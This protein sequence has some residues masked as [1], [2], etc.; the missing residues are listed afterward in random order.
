[1]RV[2]TD[3][4]ELTYQLTNECLEWLHRFGEPRFAT[5]ACVVG[6]LA[7]VRAV[8]SMPT[9]VLSEMVRAAE[10]TATLLE[11][12]QDFMAE[13]RLHEVNDP[14]RICRAALE[15][16]K[17]EFYRRIV[18]PYEDGRCAANGDV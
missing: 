8:V 5:L 15:C 9:A 16:A 10:P 12:C 1:M 3:V 2:P 17:L 7:D 11:R 6:S 13:A 14:E 18:V 4:G